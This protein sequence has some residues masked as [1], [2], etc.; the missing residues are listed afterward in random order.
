MKAA[1]PVQVKKNKSNVSNCF[2]SLPGMQF[3]FVCPV[4]AC[5]TGCTSKTVCAPENPSPDF[6]FE[7][8]ALNK[9][10]YLKEKRLDSTNCITKNNPKILQLQACKCITTKMLN[11]NN[12]LFQLFSQLIK[13][14]IISPTTRSIGFK[15]Y[16]E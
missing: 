3:Y 6:V 15:D 16:Y 7:D 4:F 11:S 13:T 5:P 12:N 9:S 10:T 1:N 14:I 2:F 8:F